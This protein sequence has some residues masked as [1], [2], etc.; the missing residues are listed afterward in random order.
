MKENITKIFKIVIAKIT[1]M[2]G[3]SRRII[4]SAIV[5]FFLS[6]AVFIQN[7]FYLNNVAVLTEENVLE[8]VNTLPN[9]SRI[10][11]PEPLDKFLGDKF[12]QD[13]ANLSLLL[14][15][16]EENKNID[17]SFSDSRGRY[18]IMVF[19]FDTVKAAAERFMYYE[20]APASPETKIPWLGF[21]KS[22]H[23]EFY[24]NDDITGSYTI[25]WYYDNTFVIIL[26]EKEE[27]GIEVKSELIKHVKKDNSK[28]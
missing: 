13:S 6:L 2:N 8:F 25:S 16:I 12:M 11:T 17:V 28:K 10:E 26:S 20:M 24:R 9:M 14:C 19:R 4:I 5:L 22:K 7:V 15:A 3:N 27:S 1:E 18:R 23:T 21:I